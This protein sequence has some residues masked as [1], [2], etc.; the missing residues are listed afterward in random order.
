MDSSGTS[1]LSQLLWKEP[2]DSLTAARLRAEQ[3]SAVLRHTPSMMFANIFNALVVVI[4]FWRTPAFSS[5]LFWAAAVFSVAGY[6]YLRQCRRRFAPHSP[7]PSSRIITRSIA[8]A[9]ILGSCWAALPIIFFQDASSGARF[10]IACLSAGMLYG[11]AFA[12]AS[13]PAAA[14]AFAGPIALAS[15][16]TLVR[17]GDREHLLAAVVLIVYSSILFRSAFAYAEQLRSR[18]LTQIHTELTAHERMQK[19]HASG[20]SAIGGMATGLAH[21]VN[22]PLAATITYL[23]TA[24]RLMRMPT[25]QRP[26]TVEDVLDKAA[27]QAMRAKE[28]IC[29]LREFIIRGEPDKTY[30]ALHDIIEEALHVTRAD[31][32]RAH[33]EISLQLDAKNDR[34]LADRVQIRQV[35][36]NLFRNAIEA[37]NASATRELTIATSLIDHQ[38]KTDITDTGRGLSEAVKTKLFEPFT[39]TKVEG[40]GVGLSISRSIIEAHHGAIWAL[41]NPSIGAAFSFVLPVEKP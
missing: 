14:V 21:E 34:I 6:I 17:S 2:S 13:I 38:I 7:A 9:L 29:N 4:T 11:G 26:A 15:F 25:E 40:M 33:V 23:E 30:V 1:S 19:L 37:M 10:L 27:E 39:T 3:F 18:V 31:A 5:A 36:V 16:V 12:L 32:S 22:Q 28:I 20:L 8:N 41:S 24:R 35:L